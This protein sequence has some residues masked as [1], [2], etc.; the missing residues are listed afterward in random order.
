MPSG[1]RGALLVAAAHISQTM[2][3]TCRPA[4]TETVRGPHCR[5]CNVE[6]NQ[7]P[8]LVRRTSSK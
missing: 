3:S 6:V 8:A 5:R 2:A 7:S 1:T 4:T